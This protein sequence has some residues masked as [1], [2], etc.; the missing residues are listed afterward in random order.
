MHSSLAYLLEFGIR[1]KRLD[2]SIEVL[3][4]TRMLNCDDFS[5]GNLIYRSDI[6][7]FRARLI[8]KQVL[9]AQH[10]CGV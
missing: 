7:V 8:R 1:S 3:D 6:V 2:T 4:Y 10:V 9:Q 5:C